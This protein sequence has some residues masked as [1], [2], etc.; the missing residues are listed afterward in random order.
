MDIWNVA[1]PEGAVI[2]PHTAWKRFWKTAASMYGNWSTTV[3]I[4]E[5]TRSESYHD[6]YYIYSCRPSESTADYEETHG[7]KLKRNRLYSDYKIRF[8]PYHEAI[9]NSLRFS[10]HEFSDWLVSGTRPG[11]IYCDPTI[12]QFRLD[13]DQDRWQV[14]IEKY[15]SSVMALG[16]YW[17]DFINMKGNTQIPAWDDRRRFYIW[18]SPETFGYSGSDYLNINWDLWWEKVDAGDAEHFTLANLLW[19]DWFLTNI[20]P[21]LDIGQTIPYMYSTRPLH[22]VYSKVA[23]VWNQDILNDYRLL[24]IHVMYELSKPLPVRPTDY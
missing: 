4:G 11:L 2:D 3:E 12:H 21:L 15:E 14:D 17:S 8:S 10:Y 19:C 20:R 9:H 24:P 13:E 7:L 1:F 5:R 23:D 16:N 22:F 6:G 18:F